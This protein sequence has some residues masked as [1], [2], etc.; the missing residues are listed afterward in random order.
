MVI[1]IKIS[2]HQDRRMMST[3]LADNGYKT[4]IETEKDKYNL[5]RCDYV[6]FEINNKDTE[7]NDNNTVFFKTLD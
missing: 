4:W 2:N 5:D 6:C 3:I 7:A 1:K